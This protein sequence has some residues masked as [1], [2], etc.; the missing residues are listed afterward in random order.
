MAPALP[1][2]GCAISASTKKRTVIPDCEGLRR[3]TE[4]IPSVVKMRYNDLVPHGLLERSLSD[5]CSTSRCAMLYSIFEFMECDT[6]LMNCTPFGVQ[7]ILFLRI[8]DINELQGSVQEPGE[9]FK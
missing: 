3:T 6:L 4:D 5:V 8:I 7:D 9:H 1:L 2:E